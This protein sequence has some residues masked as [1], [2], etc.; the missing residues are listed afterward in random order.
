MRMVSVVLKTVGKELTFREKVL[1][2]SAR[3]LY[4]SDPDLKSS[5]ILSD[6]SVKH[7]K[8]GICFVVG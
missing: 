2:Q 5:D 3:E 4:M 1:R 6:G 8:A 7:F